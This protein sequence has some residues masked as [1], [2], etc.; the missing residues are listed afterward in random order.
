MAQ[1]Y[2]Q[3]ADRTKLGTDNRT[4]TLDG[5]S[6]TIAAQQLV[7]VPGNALAALGLAVGEI[8]LEQLK[9]G[10]AVDANVDGSS[11]AAK[12]EYRVPADQVLLLE[13]LV[14][15]VRDTGAWTGGGFGALA[16]LTNG[17]KL[18]VIDVD[19]N[20]VKRSLVPGT[21]VKTT[22]AIAAV[23]GADATML[24]ADTLRARLPAGVGGWPIVVTAQQYVRLTVADNLTG[25]DGM[26]ASIR[27]R[28]AA[29]SA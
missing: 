8:L 29:A 17:L 16:A 24:L 23:P 19:G 18:E 20:T 25:L 7:A 13:E 15:V 21:V 28:L 1:D 5:K 3:L 27:G 9:N 10:A 2:L 6:H 22:A 26:L 12:F 11:A 14:L 4:V